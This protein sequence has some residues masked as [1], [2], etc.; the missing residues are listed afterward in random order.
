MNADP[1]DTALFAW[2]EETFF[3]GGEGGNGDAERSAIDAA[4][5]GSTSL[6]ATGNAEQ[7]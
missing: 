2:L 7:W 5:A 6:T 1:D 4:L 3:K